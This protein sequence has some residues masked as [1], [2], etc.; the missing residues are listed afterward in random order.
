MFAVNARKKCGEAAAQPLRGLFMRV[1][2]YASILA[3]PPSTS[4]LNFL[5]LA[6]NVTVLVNPFTRES[7]L[8][9][10]EESDFSSVTS[11]FLGH[12]TPLNQHDPTREFA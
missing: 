8:L 4:E 12:N 9:K 6:I 5:S 3:C 11:V 2:V 10:E 1:T 7:I